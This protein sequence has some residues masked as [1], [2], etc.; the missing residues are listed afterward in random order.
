MADVP[1]YIGFMRAINL[2]AKRKFPKDDIRRAVESL[3]FGDVGTHINTGNIR[4][5]TPMRSRARIED[6]LEQAFLADRGFAVPTIVFS[7]A[8]FAALAEETVDLAAAHPHAAR[9]YVDLLRMELSREDAEHLERASNE[10]S[11]FHVRG[12]SVH[13]LLPETI[14]GNLPTPVT[15]GVSTNRNARVVVAIAAKWC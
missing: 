3:G 5:T 8:E 10:V 7:T 11:S 13:T 12:R 2:G 6:A 1:T 15:L 4:F 9:H 14:P